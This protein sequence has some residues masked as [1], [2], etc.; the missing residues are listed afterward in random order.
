MAAASSKMMGTGNV[1]L[2]KVC[3]AGSFSQDQRCLQSTERSGYIAFAAW[4]KA[5]K[6]NTG[7]S[8]PEHIVPMEMLLLAATRP[9]P[10]APTKQ[11]ACHH[12]FKETS[13]VSESLSKSRLMKVTNMCAS[14]TKGA[15]PM[16][17]R[18]L[19]EPASPAKA[20][21]PALAVPG[22]C[23]SAQR[24]SALGEA[25]APCLQGVSRAAAWSPLQRPKAVGSR[26]LR[27]GYGQ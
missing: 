6:V 24:T 9:A 26:L 10:G 3:F 12:D 15:F 17:P 4:Q 14:G 1:S 7:E 13:S 19:E 22:R 11:P 21:A 5:S 16:E 2:K 8:V 27:I 23:P 20:A 25:A 18:V